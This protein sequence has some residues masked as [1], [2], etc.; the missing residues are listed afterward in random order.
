MVCTVLG[1]LSNK[2]IHTLSS[3]K[4]ASPTCQLLELSST[5]VATILIYPAPPDPSPRAA[6]P[7]VLGTRRGVPGASSQ[8]AGEH[9][10]STAPWRRH[11]VKRVLRHGGAEAGARCH[12]QA[13]QRTSACW[14]ARWGEARWGEVR[15]TGPQRVTA[16]SRRPRT[17]RGG[18]AMRSRALWP[19][20]GQSRPA[21]TG[22][23]PG[24][25]SRLLP[26]APPRG[27]G[28]GPLPGPPPRALALWGSHPAWP[29]GGAPPPNTL[30][31]R[32]RGEEGGGSRE[33]GTRRRAQARG[34]CAL[35]P[36]AGLVVAALRGLAA[37]RVRPPP[38]PPWGSRRAPPPSPPA[39]APSCR[40]TARGRPRHPADPLPG[41]PR[42]GGGGERLRG[43]DPRPLAPGW[44][45]WGGGAQH[46]GGQGGGARPPRQ[47]EWGG[48]R[49]GQRGGVRGRE[50]GGGTPGRPGHRRR[51]R[52]CGVRGAAAAA[53][54]QGPD[55]R[56]RRSPGR[57][58]AGAGVR[59]PPSSPRT[60][61][62]RPVRCSCPL[63]SGRRAVLAPLA[64][65][66][67]CH[68]GF[69]QFSLSSPSG[70]RPGVVLGSVLASL[71]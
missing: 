11:A 61:G 47:G 25:T 60:G 36:R 24:R 52:G 51:P 50:V 59:G 57:R 28:A 46:G 55:R 29:W 49:G 48:V 22:S 20:W 27:A 56:S 21:R 69:L 16:A 15:P 42:R 7:P 26:R 14:S 64:S 23:L 34:A 9:S 54:V 65:E 71:R 33:A 18:H 39:P 5:E 68:S 58:T 37:W 30:T 4:A 19:P 12:G 31:L 62:P 3:R 13:R 10:G 67:R 45:S 32:L 35:G 41:A 43:S 38:P 6:S 17:R 1:T 44:D 40:S 2:Q 70:E 63:A 66:P 53:A 8:D